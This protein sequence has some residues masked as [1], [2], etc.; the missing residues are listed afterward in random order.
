MTKQPVNTLTLENGIT[1]SWAECGN[2]LDCCILNEQWDMEAA[3][4]VVDMSP[5][6]VLTACVLCRQV[7]GDT[8][9]ERAHRALNVLLYDPRIQRG[10]IHVLF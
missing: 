7:V 1:V 6:A 5:L 3:T 9:A 10:S 4:Y 8:P 2:A